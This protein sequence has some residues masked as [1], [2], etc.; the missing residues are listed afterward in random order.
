[1]ITQ[2]S[3]KEYAKAMVQNRAL[4]LLKQDDSHARKIR[5][6][7]AYQAKIEG[8]LQLA[9][10]VLVDGDEAERKAVAAEI[11]TVLDAGNEV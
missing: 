2:V 1:M 4:S 11:R 10:R 8:A 3:S 6:H 7:L 9:V 5:E